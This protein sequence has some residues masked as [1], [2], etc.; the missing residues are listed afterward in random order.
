MFEF[1]HSS[2]DNNDLRYLL[3]CVYG[4]NTTKGQFYC[5]LAFPKR[6]KN[7]HLVV[8]THNFLIILLKLLAP[9]ERVALLYVGWSVL[10]VVS[11][12]WSGSMQL[13]GSEYWSLSISRIK[14]CYSMAMSVLVIKG[15]GLLS[16]SIS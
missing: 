10:E 14:F 2:L 11:K 16:T 1:E 12:W 5:Q 7:Y 4:S 15:P 13:I 6:G 8:L 9:C 3:P